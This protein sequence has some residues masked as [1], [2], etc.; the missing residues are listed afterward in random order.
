VAELVAN[1]PNATF[2]PESI[3]ASFRLR[4]SAAAY[5][6]KIVSRLPPGAMDMLRPSSASDSPEIFAAQVFTAIPLKRF[7]VGHDSVRVTVRPVLR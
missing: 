1:L 6:G 7:L 2:D 5:H 4:D 3:V